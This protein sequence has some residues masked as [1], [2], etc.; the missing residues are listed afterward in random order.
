M[1]EGTTPAATLAATVSALIVDDEPIARAGLR[2]ALAEHDW[3]RVI[4]EAASGPAALEQIDAL[5]PELVFLDIRM[6]GFSGLELLA[7]LPK[8]REPPR[9]IFT[10]AFAEHAVT[11]FELGALD[12]LLKP[13]G[14]DRLRAALDRARAAF[15]EPMPALG[16]RWA[17]AFGSAPMHRI[18]VRQGRAIVPLATAGVAWFEALGDYVALHLAAGA[19]PGGAPLVHLA[20]ARL[21]SRL[22]GQRFV[23]IHRTHIVNLDHVLAFRRGEGGTLVAE[24]KGGQ[25]L[26]V[27]RAMAQQVRALAR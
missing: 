12:Y 6:P 19:P 2:H 1:A 27:G 22:D 25:R 18:F 7:Q 24:M 9:V 5:A 10:T 13:F 15:G 4:G 3:L 14:P 17:E 8:S 11:A 23:R 16:E 20:L 26:A 21:A